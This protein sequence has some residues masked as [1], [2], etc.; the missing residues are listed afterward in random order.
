VHPRRPGARVRR[1]QDA[2]LGAGQEIAEAAA[3]QASIGRNDG[4][5]SIAA[6]GSVTFTERA[7]RAVAAVAPWLTEPLHPDGAL[8]RA[9][10]IAKLLAV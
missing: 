2:N 6:D 4:V 7:R 8:E 3:W 9:E 5:E 1:G 10:R